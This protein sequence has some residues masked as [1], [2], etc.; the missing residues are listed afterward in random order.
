MKKTLRAIFFLHL[1]NI[2]CTESST[3]SDSPEKKVETISFQIPGC[4]APGLIKAKGIEEYPCFKYNFTD[5]LRIEFCVSGNCCPD[6]FRF[7]SEI[8]IISDT[9]FVSVVDTAENLCYCDCL[10]KM[11]LEITG[12]PENKYLFYCD[13]ESHTETFKYREYI[14]K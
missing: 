6:S 7:A 13:F 4:R 1:L 14:N 3:N 5:T 8:N 2:N 12:L 9:I 10:Y 11:H